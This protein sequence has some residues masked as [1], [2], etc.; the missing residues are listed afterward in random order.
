MTPDRPAPIAV[1]AYNRPG[2]LLRTLEALARNDGAGGSPLYI[3]CDGPKPDA[4]PEM[5]DRVARTQ[6]IA[7]KQGFARQAIVRISPE[8]RGLAASIISGV[9]D[10]LEEHGRI[11]VLEDDLETA[12]H[13][14]TFMNRALDFYAN[15]PAVFSIG[16]F[17]HG[18]R[19]LGIPA[20]H[21]HDAFVSLRFCSWGF[22]TWRDRWNR[23]DWNDPA[24]AV[25]LSQPAC[26]TAFNRGGDDLAKLLQQQLDG[27]IDS[28]AIRFDF[29]QF[30]HHGVTVLPCDS[31]VR[32]TGLDGS[33]R[34]C[35]ATTVH[36]EIHFQPFPDPL[37]LPEIL[38]ED[39]RV[40]AAMRRIMRPPKRPFKAR[41]AK[42]W[43]RILR[44]LGAGNRTP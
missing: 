43:R 25:C 26:K 12:P 18:R 36:P 11:I 41:L 39:P 13:F 15:F 6:D 4:S 14:L 44:T 9:T 7:K 30:K 19:H 29:A 37:R 38:A 31:L 5:L 17:S 16:G 23:V 22:A 21:A 40:T 27:K 33:G 34:H 32:N 10:I 2:H 3:L 35:D 28:W 8:N 24:R 20:D 42:K 1:F